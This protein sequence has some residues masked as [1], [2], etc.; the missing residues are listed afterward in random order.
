MTLSRKEPEYTLEER[1]ARMFPHWD[2]SRTSNPTY[3]DLVQE[4]SRQ[5]YVALSMAIDTLGAI[6]DLVRELEQLRLEQE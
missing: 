1:S 6:R 3:K 5:L 2:H 4:K